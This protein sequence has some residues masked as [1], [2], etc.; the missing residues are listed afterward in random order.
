MQSS[1]ESLSSLH[2]EDKG[3]RSKNEDKDE[4]ID[5]RTRI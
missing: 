3:R 1:H 2:F 4:D 5:S